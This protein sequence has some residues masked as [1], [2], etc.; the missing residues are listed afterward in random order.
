MHTQLATVSSNAVTLSSRSSSTR[1]AGAG[2]SRFLQTSA[3]AT[4]GTTTTCLVLRLPTLIG[5]V[6]AR[7]DEAASSVALPTRW[8]DISR[9]RDCTADAAD[10]SVADVTRTE[11]LEQPPKLE[12]R[13]PTPRETREAFAQHLGLSTDGEGG[14]AACSA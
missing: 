3:P 7:R 4:R 14:A 13:W 8:A 10:T 1:P 9:G 2:F 5:V 12:E 11:A 6:S